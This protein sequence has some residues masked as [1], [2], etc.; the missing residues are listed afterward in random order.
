MQG[1][2]YTHGK[3]VG[4]GAKLKRRWWE[5]MEGMEVWRE[6]YV[7]KMMKVVGICNSFKVPVITRLFFVKDDAGSFTSTDDER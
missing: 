7:R 4:L 5:R 3:W 6:D 1:T 2:V